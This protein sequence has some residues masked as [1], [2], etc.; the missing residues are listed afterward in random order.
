MPIYIKELK[1]KDRSVH[2]KI[3]MMKDSFA[4]DEYKPRL[5]L[6][7]MCIET[8]LAAVDVATVTSR[9]TKRVI[10]S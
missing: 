5:G 10:C 7:V 1:S 9:T 8:K 4:L 2:A 6:V 3:A